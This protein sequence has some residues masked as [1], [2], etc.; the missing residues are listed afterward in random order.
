M[1][2]LS[3]GAILAFPA[4]LVAGLEAASDTELEGVTVA[5]DGY[6]LSWAGRDVFL[7]YLGILTDIFGARAHMTRLAGPKLKTR[8]ER[9]NAPTRRRPRR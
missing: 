1:V 2:E 4:R 3:N 8:E 5:G 7:S 9:L 6:V